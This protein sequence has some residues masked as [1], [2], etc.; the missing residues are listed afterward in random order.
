MKTTQEL[1]NE[2]DRIST[3]EEL[4]QV[5]A[6]LNEFAR[7][8]A[9]EPTQRARERKALRDAVMDLWQDAAADEHESDHESPDGAM[10]R[11]AVRWCQDR[12][13]QLTSIN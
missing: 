7:T 5:L 4:H 10:Y 3:H 11:W 2:F 12:P 8:Q 1:S 6:L 9:T 13:S